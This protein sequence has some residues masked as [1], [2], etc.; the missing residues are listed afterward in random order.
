MV[1]LEV[2]AGHLTMNLKPKHASARQKQVTTQ[3]WEQ[4]RQGQEATILRPSSEKNGL[5]L[6][7]IT[8]HVAMT[9]TPPKDSYHHQTDTAQGQTGVSSVCVCVFQ[10]VFSVPRTLGMSCC[11]AR[12][13]GNTLFYMKQTKAATNRSPC[14]CARVTLP[15]I[16][17]STET[18]TTTTTANSHTADAPHTARRSSTDQA[19]DVQ[20]HRVGESRMNCANTVFTRTPQFILEVLLVDGAPPHMGSPFEGSSRARAT[21]RWRQRP[22]VETCRQG[23]AG[24]AHATS[25]GA[26]HGSVDTLCTSTAD[27]GHA[28]CKCVHGGARA[29][30]DALRM[31][32]CEAADEIARRSVNEHPALVRCW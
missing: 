1:P 18:T 3:M 14:R 4:A 12:T 13:V 22:P 29:Q 15:R 7:S 2:V 17:C 32:L 27:P 25:T 11:A 21:P 30:P 19:S 28:M 16:V 6:S 26:R 9:A 10:C 23:R 8:H 5:D 24:P 20:V 31:T